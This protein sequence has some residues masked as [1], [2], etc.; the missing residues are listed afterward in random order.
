MSPSREPVGARVE[1]VSRSSTREP[2]DGLGAQPLG[3]LPAHGAQ[4]AADGDRGAGK[5]SGDSSMPGA[6]GAGQQRRAG[7]GRGVRGRG[8]TAPGS[9][10]WV[11]R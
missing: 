11:A 6:A 10:T 4:P 3:A 8:S 5:V 2:V 9:S 7:H 1:M